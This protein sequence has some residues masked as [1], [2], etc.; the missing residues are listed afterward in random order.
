MKIYFIH[1]INYPNYANDLYKVIRESALNKSHRI[2]LP[3]E[4]SDYP[5]NSKAIIKTCD[6]V[7]AE[8]SYASLGLGIELGWAD[9]ERRKILCIHKEGTKPSS[10]LKLISCELIKYSSQQDMVTTL[11]QWLGKHARVFAAL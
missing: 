6:L 10:A 5:V 4:K 9:I 2:V 1:A 3:H 7:I 8:V 11:M